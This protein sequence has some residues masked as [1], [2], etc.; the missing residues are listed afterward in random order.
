M[1]LGFSCK[2]TET[3]I[4][5][6]SKPFRQLFCFVFVPH[7]I[8]LLHLLISPLVCFFFILFFNITSYRLMCSTSC[9]ATM[10]VWWVKQYGLA[11]IIT[12]LSVIDYCQ[13]FY[14]SRV[15]WLNWCHGTIKYLCR[16]FTIKIMQD[17][18]CTVSRSLNWW[19]AFDVKRLEEVLTLTMQER[20]ATA[21]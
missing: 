3:L 8:I 7:I 21:H 2:Q 20:P 9:T 16:C 4:C 6:S 1:T 14:Y 17:W 12:I 11:I 13:S 10:S 18:K 5:C 15:S 19:K